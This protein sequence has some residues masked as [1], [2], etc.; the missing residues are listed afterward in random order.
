[1]RVLA[2]S[3]TMTETEGMDQ[4]KPALDR[5]FGG[6][7]S[8]AAYAAKLPLRRLG[9]PDDIARTFLLLASNLCIFL[10]GSTVPVDGD[11]TF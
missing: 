9:Q 5:A 11:L 1:M 2:V 8:H 6:T 10:T 3:P 4:Q 7:D